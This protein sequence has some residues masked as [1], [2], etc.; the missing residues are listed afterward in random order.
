MGRGDQED[1]QTGQDMGGAMG[2]EKGDKNRKG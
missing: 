2:E 1:R